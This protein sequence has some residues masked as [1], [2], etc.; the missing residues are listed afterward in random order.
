VTQII[1]NGVNVICTFLGLYVMERYGR[2][3]P[4]IIGGLWQSA[5]FFV[6]ASVGVTHDPTTSP[7]AAKVMI[8][9]ACFLLV[10]TNSSGRA[11]FACLQHL[12]L[13]KHL[14]AR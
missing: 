6:Y 14:G 5:W 13:R 4:L 12:G 8:C 9:S 10:S 1:L 7:G 2:R 11:D 3:N